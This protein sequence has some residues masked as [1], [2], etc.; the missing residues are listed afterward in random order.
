MTSICSL[1]FITTTKVCTLVSRCC[2]SQSPLS[3]AYL[4]LLRML[5]I[6]VQSNFPEPSQMSQTPRYAL[7]VI[8]MIRKSPLTENVCT[9]F[10]RT[11]LSSNLCCKLVPVD[12]VDPFLRSSQQ[13][14]SAK[15]DSAECTNCHNTHW[16]HCRTSIAGGGSTCAGSSTCRSL[17]CSC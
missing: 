8:C 2:A 13:C 10:K 5:L 17:S 9:L 14:N 7:S 4:F 16:L 1:Y 6:S 11:S 3:Y 12:I 15:G